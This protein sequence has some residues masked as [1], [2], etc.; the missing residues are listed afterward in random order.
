MIYCFH[1]KKLYLNDIEFVLGV[2]NSSINNFIYRN[3]T[4]EKGR[5]FAEVK[6]KNVRK[7]YIPN[8]EDN[9]IHEVENCVRELLEN[10]DVEKNLNTINDKLY[11]FY[12][13]NKEEIELI[14]K[15]VGE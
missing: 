12:R 1:H 4:Q 10:T 9:D 11:E 7:L 3:L 2:L 5:A 8:M 6:P 14:E 15:E 13:L